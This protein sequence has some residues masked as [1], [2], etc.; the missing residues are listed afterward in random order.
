MT[1]SWRGVPTKRE[2]RAEDLIPRAVRNP[3]AFHFGALADVP[4]VGAMVQEV[5]DWFTAAAAGEAPDRAPL[6]RAAAQIAQMK[7]QMG[8]LV[9]PVT[10]TL[11]STRA[12]LLY[13]RQ[14]GEVREQQI[15]ALERDLAILRQERA[16]IEAMVDTALAGR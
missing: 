13:Q 2:P 16:K 12:E 7:S 6:E 8:V 1:D 3:L 5:L 15:K 11:D 10:N 4:M 9:T 14:L